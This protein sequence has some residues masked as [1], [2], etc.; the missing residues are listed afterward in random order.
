LGADVPSRLRLS[1]LPLTC[2]GGRLGRAALL[3]T[4]DQAN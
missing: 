3:V 1:T 2:L 4:D